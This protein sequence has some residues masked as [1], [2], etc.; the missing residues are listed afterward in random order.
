MH[1]SLKVKGFFRLQIEENGKIVGDSGIDKDGKLVN[2]DGFI[3]NQITNTGFSDYLV[4]TLLGA[5]GSKRVG[6]IALGTGAAP[7][8]NATALPGEI[9][10]STQ[11]K[12]P[13]TSKVGNTTA[14][15]AATFA[16]SD[17]FITGAS[18][19]SNIGLF[20]SS[21]ANQ[22]M[23]GLAYTSSSLNTNQNVNVTYQIRFS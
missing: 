11:R 14:Q 16:S 2:G 8:S 21:A 22:I 12:A 10:S 19:I 23:A 15:Y 4:G 7:A 9:M 13:T 17:S 18:N 6:F 3:Q 5:A 20:A 1:D